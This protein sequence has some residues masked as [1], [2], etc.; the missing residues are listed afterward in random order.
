MIRLCLVAL[1]MVGLGAPVQAVEIFFNGGAVL[2]GKSATCP[3]WLNVGNRYQVFYFF[4][5]AGT[6]NGNTSTIS[7]F[8]GPGAD[9]FQLNN[10]TFDTTFK[11]ATAT[12]IFSRAGTY[13][14]QVKRNQQFPATVDS[15]TRF[16]SFRFQVLGFDNI[17][18]CLVTY[19]ASAVR[20]PN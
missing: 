8:S 2:L 18:T 13:P 16:L 14:V 11:D 17:A 19:D 10:G 3:S 1:M 6:D 9:A 15:T 7:I 5:I 4:P 20:T 12:H